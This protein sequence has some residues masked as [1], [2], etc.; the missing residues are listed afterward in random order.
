MDMFG[1]V[2]FCIVFSVNWLIERID[3]WMS[4]WS[5]VN[6]RL[7]G[8]AEDWGFCKLSWAIQ[9]EKSNGIDP[10]PLSFAII[11]STALDPPDEGS[12]HSSHLQ[13]LQCNLHPVPPKPP[14][15]TG[16]IRLMILGCKLDS[17]SHA[18]SPINW[19]CGLDLPE[20]SFPHL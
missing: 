9:G 1:I 12:V 3:E 20:S 5:K 18:C 17:H 13:P 2:W 14:P 7:L 4:E 11:Y 15:H 19:W 10:R 6:F 16:S 8:W